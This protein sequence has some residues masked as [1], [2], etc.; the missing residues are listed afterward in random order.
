MILKVLT[1]RFILNLW[2]YTSLSQ[3][4]R[5]TNARQL[6]NG[7]RVDGTTSN[8]DFFLRIDSML[9]AIA[10]E[11]DA[12]SLVSIKNNIGNSSTAENVQVRAMSV[13]SEVASRGV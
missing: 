6:E 12:S 13:C 2:L 7:R 11:L 3:N 8:D 10:D 5:I 1:N 9:L 4:L